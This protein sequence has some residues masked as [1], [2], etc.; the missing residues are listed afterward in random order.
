MRDDVLPGATRAGSTAQPV[1]WRQ[2]LATWRWR[3]RHVIVAYTILTPMVVYF[4]VFHWAPVVVL[5]GLSLTEWDIISWPPT[6]VGLANFAKIAGDEYY[7]NVV[8][9]TVTLGAAV[10]AVDMA[11]GLFIAL[12]LNEPIRGRG[13]YRTLWYLPVV[14]SGAVMAQVLLVFLYPGRVGVFNG[15]LGLVGVEPVLWTRST[16]WMPVWVIVFVIWRSIGYVVIFFLAGLQSVDPAIHEAARV[17]GCNRW[18]SFWHITVPQL[19]PIT[20]FVLVTQSVSS[21]QIWEAPLILTFG[22]PEESTRTLVYSLYS[23]A[24]G[25]LAVGLAATQS[26]LLLVVLMALSATNLRLFRVR[27]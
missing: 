18:Q 8:R 16:F 22:G 19:A 7:R 17:D 12:L 15:L 21:L 26:V 20:L 9:V 1:P 4:G 14:I 10:L 6:F 13:V 25:N 23:D 5:W 2:R 24:F 3:H 27:Y 11:L